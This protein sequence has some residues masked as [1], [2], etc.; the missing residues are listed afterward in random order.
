MRQEDRVVLDIG[1]AQ[2]G[3][4]GNIVEAGK[5]VVGGAGAQHGRAHMTQLVGTVHHG[6]R[7]RVHE[8]RGVGAAGPFGPDSGR[9][10]EVGAQRGAHRAKALA[11]VFGAGD[12]QTVARDRNHIARAQLLCQPRDMFG[13][14]RHPQ[15]HQGQAAAGKFLFRLGEVAGIGPQAAPGGRDDQGAGGPREA[16]Q[17]FP[18]LPARRQVLGEVG[19]GGGDDDGGDAFAGHGGAKDFKTGGDGLGSHSLMVKRQLR[20][21]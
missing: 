3:Q 16:G 2:V 20:F 13:S 21:V 10:V 5:K 18:G 6:E 14:V 15:P 17:P 9:Q 7:R 1:A 11:E 4:P 19:V 8:D 12:V